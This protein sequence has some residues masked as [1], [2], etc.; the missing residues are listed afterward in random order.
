MIFGILRATEDGA[1]APPPSAVIAV[2]PLGSVEPGAIARLI[3]LL[4]GAFRSEVVVVSPL[5]LPD[6]GWNTRRRQHLSTAILDELAPA[7]RPEWERLLGVCDVDLY[8][9]DLNFVFGQ[10]DAA[11]QVAVF[12]LRRLH[13]AGAGTEAQQLFERR[14]ATEAIHELGHTYGLGH[15]DD[16]RCVMWFSNTLAESDRKGTGFCSR[17]AV[18]LARARGP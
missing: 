8:V 17:H 18:A 15:C 3:P 6:R 11:R 2:A 14:A 7:R 16:P 1:T 10:A 5:P 12:S 4:G 13:P 9:P